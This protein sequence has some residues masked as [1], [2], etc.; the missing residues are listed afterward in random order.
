MKIKEAGDAMEVMSL[1]KKNFTIL[2]FG[3]SHYNDMQQ[4][5]IFFVNINEK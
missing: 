4:A 1:K 2:K 5:V 3:G